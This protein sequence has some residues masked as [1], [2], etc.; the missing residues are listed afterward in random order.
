MPPCYKKKKL[1]WLITDIGIYFK[2]S[3]SKNEMLESFPSKL[4]INFYTIVREICTFT[5]NKVK[6]ICPL[7]RK[8]ELEM[9]NN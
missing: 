8:K 3:F 4:L 9:V 7:V 2:V 6:E 5:S 1:K